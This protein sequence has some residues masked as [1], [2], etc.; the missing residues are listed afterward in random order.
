MLHGSKAL[1]NAMLA[2]S[3]ARL[4]FVVMPV[5]YWNKMSLQQCQNLFPSA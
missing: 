1:K 4:G 5:L 3:R 2:F